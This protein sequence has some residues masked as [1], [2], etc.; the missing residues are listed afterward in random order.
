MLYAHMQVS[1]YICVCMCMHVYEMWLLVCTCIC[2]R[3]CVC[4]YVFKQQAYLKHATYQK[5][6][7]DNRII[8]CNSQKGI[9]AAVISIL[10]PLC[11]NRI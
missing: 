10:Q 1:V 9:S 7:D 11:M 6:I 8:I 5:S 2:V 4:V 3:V